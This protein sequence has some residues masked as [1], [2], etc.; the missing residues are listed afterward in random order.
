VQCQ[1]PFA[2]LTLFP[3]S[4]HSYARECYPPKPP[5]Y[6]GIPVLSG[7]SKQKRGVEVA[8][9]GMNSNSS[10]PLFQI[11]KVLPIFH[12]LPVEAEIVKCSQLICHSPIPLAFLRLLLAIASDA[13]DKKRGH[14]TQPG[15]LLI[16]GTRHVHVCLTW[17]HSKAGVILYKATAIL[18]SLPDLYHPTCFS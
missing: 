17:S 10:A 5:K 18:A 7:A 14:L 16:T 1:F 15:K 9:S 8:F 4:H 12:T 11:E 6:K 2:C 3:L 13:S